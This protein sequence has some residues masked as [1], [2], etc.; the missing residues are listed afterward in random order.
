MLRKEVE[1]VERDLWNARQR[2]VFNDHSPAAEWRRS[3]QNAL[4]RIKV[5]LALVEA[6]LARYD[7]DL[8]RMASELLI[9][10][11]DEE[12]DLDENESA[13]IDKLDERQK[14]P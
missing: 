6:W 7:A 12:V 9:R 10:L 14:N 13:F 11:R 4:E 3:A 8:L 2:P 1:R 5:D